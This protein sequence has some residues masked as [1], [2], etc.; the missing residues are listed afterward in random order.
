MRMPVPL[1]VAVPVTEPVIMEPVAGS[2]FVGGRTAMYV[3]AG[4][5]VW[6]VALPPGPGGVSG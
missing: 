6:I 4:L 2:K 1:A 3:A 5:E